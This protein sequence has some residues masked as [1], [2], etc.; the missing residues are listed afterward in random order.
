MA[1]LC[2]KL[3]ERGRKVLQKRVRKNNDGW[4][5]KIVLICM[6]QNNFYP[7]NIT[8]TPEELTHKKG[9]RAM[10]NLFFDFLYSGC[11]NLDGISSFEKKNP[12]C[13]VSLSA[14]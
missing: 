13:V 1:K 4:Y 6:M 5:T 14:L 7:C 10:P 9:G 12:K 3:S 11:V 8:S 2:S